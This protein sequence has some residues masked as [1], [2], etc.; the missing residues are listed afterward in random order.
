MKYSVVRK[1]FVV[2]AVGVVLGLPFSAAQAGLLDNLFSSK[3]DLNAPGARSWRLDQFSGITLVA[4]E[5]SA[6]PNQHPASVN[7]DALVGQLATLEVRARGSWE[8]LFDPDELKQ[9]APALVRALAA[10]GPSDDLL[11]LSTARRGGTFVV[12]QAV[13]ARV[14]VEGGALNVIVRDARNEFLETYNR[15]R[16]DPRFEFGSRQS[17][18][19]EAT[20]APGGSG[21][22]EDWVRIPLASLAA[23]V[24]PLPTDAA[25]PV[26]Q[27]P[28][29]AAPV[30]AAPVVPVA[31]PAVPPPAG[32]PAAIA[33]EVEQRLVTLKRLRD[34]G[35][36]TEEEYQQKRREV[37]QKL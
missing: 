31:A 30:A 7:A 34:R 22:R 21:P 2:P 36:I 15:T 12:P 20:R 13:T 33:D 11:L 4:K 6:A 5:P 16:R 9:L 1:A 17:A 3:P 18:G 29:A 14:F 10:A 26:A 24:V 19:R 27:P 23:G 32:S 37:L 28:K 8:P 25:R 35:L